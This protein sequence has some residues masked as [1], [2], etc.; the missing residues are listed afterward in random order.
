MQG[1][2]FCGRP[3]PSKWA[4][5]ARNGDPP[6]DRWRREIVPVCPRCNRLLDAAGHNGRKLKGKKEWWY[7]GHTVGRNFDSPGARAMHERAEWEAEREWQ[8][9]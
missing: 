3:T 8:E 6:N 1:C 4:V 2:H 9:G 7:P 5:T